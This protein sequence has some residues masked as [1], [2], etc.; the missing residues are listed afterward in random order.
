MGTL[1][2][3]L[4][5]TAERSPSAI[6]L[7]YGDHS[8]SYAELAGAVDRLAHGLLGLPLAPD[9]RVAV[10]LEKRP[11]SVITLLAATRAGGVFVPV[12]P[13]LKP[14]QVEHILRDC[15]VR[16]LVTST[17][18]L[19]A[20]ES[21]LDRCMDLHSILL[22]DDVPSP[23]KPAQV[24]CVPWP[25]VSAGQAVP[26]KVPRRI[27]SDLAAILYTSGSTGRP[28][29][30]VLSH[31]NLVAGAESVSTYLQ[32]TREDRIL[33]V[34]PLSF[35]YGLSQITTALRVGAR[36][37][38]M[39]YLLPRDVIR[40]VERHRV[41]GLAAVPPLWNQLAQLPWPESVGDHLRYMTNSGGAM[42]RATLTAL[43][44]ALPATKV[45]LMYG[46]TEAFRSTYLPPEE[47]DRRPDSIGKAIPNAEV[48]V[49][50][51]DGSHC[52]TNEPGELVHRGA[53]VSMGY[54]N[55]PEKTSERFKPAPG[56]PG[57]ITITELAVWSGD[58]VRADEE[59]F[60]YFI[61]R[62]DEMIK[63]SGY[64]VSPNE[65]EEVVYATGMVGEA[66]AVGV[67]HPTLGQAIV[68]FT[69][70]RT[71]GAPPAPNEL[72]A[73]TQRSLPGFMVPAR[74]V[75]REEPLPRNPN[76]KIDRKRLAL[77]VAETF[78]NGEPRT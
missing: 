27:D 31:R 14:P 23:K 73:A 21:A 55:D 48:L 62:R 64:R 39:N 40:A 41:T 34:L 25:D 69:V 57:A 42:P 65:V 5:A 36:A 4:D 2:A 13:L 20:L 74:I 3:M 50:R 22:V 38:L 67:P 8:L 32:N 10:Y 47:V 76:G 75:V 49:V 59:G 60:L 16:C 12:N 56:R 15:N 53:L 35:D 51:E 17:S 45:F 1:H 43:R 24:Q 9:D 71:G 77:E 33:A 63:T 19:S 30:V 68:L 54:W 52:A 18:R 58:T 29:G 66:A 28:K 11:E 44:R 72:L 6:S 70:P 61:G 37:V 78:C 26:T 46:L 7:E